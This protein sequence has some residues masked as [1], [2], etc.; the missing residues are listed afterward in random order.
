MARR[1][2]MIARAYIFPADSAIVKSSIVRGR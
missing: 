2:K 1:L